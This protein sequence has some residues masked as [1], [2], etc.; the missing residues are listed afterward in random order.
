MLSRVYARHMPRHELHLHLPR[1]TI[2][3]TDAEIVVWSGDSLLGRLLV[4]KGGIDWWPANNKKVHY[5]LGWERFAEAIPEW[6]RQ[7]SR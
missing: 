1:T 7:K 3:K 6:G 4:S 2:T 5:T